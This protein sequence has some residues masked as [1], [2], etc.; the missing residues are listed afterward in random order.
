MTLFLWH[1][2]AFIAVT[3]AGLLAGG[4][5]G[6]QTA[7]SSLAW[8]GERLAW[9]PAFAVVLVALWAVF[10]RAERPRAPRRRS[11]ADP[12]LATCDRPTYTV[13]T[14]SPESM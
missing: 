14:S 8:V 2:T 4:L 10:R 7:P 12:A 5:P 1:Q 13:A 11:A 9:L 6:L 3:A